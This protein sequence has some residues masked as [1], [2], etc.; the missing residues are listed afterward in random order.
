MMHRC[1][2]FKSSRVLLSRSRKKLR[3]FEFLFSYQSEQ[4]YRLRSLNVFGKLLDFSQQHAPPYLQLPAIFN[5]Y[6][7]VK[8][9]GKHCRKPIAC[10]CRYV[11]TMP[12]KTNEWENSNV[13]NF[14]TDL[15][16]NQFR[17]YKSSGFY[18][19]NIS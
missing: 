17:F 7:Y 9:R 19:T 18:W 10:G 3:K 11:G 6:Y 15:Y 13:Y 8:L 1:L 16:N 12:F 14:L 2:W 4:F 5:T